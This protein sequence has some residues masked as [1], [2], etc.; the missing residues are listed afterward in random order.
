MTQPI[1]YDSSE[2]GAPTLN[3]VA[4]SLLT[5]LRACLISGFN[6]KSVTSIT[7]ASGVATVTCAAHGFSGTY[8]K[9]VQISG[10]TE[11]LLNGNKQPGNVLTNSFTFPAPGVA[12][13]TYTGT[14]SAK[15]APL[16]WTEP[17]TG[18]NVAMF[19][20][21]VPEA[22][23][24][25][26][27]VDDSHSA[28]STVTDARMSMVESATS[29]NNFTDETPTSA[30]VSGGFHVS[31]G[32]NSVTAKRWVIFGTGREIWLGSQASPGVTDPLQMYFFGDCISY[33]SPDPY[34][35]IIAGA[36]AA[37]SGTAN[38]SLL[39]SWASVNSANLMGGNR[40]AVARD[41]KGT[42]KS[43]ICNPVGLFSGVANG[44]AIGGSGLAQSEAVGVN[45]LIHQYVWIQ[46]PTR[47]IRGHFPGIK[48]PLG[49]ALPF[50]DMQILGD[51]GGSGRSF[52]SVRV[53]T[54]F[55]A[56]NVLFDLTGPWG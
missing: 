42:D 34:A 40:I 16:G 20:R 51:V 1:W 17:H 44:N 19:A 55:G 26:L 47:P 46:Q 7:V 5:V 53:G 54:A 2:A 10:A 45:V 50:S 25:L 39:G 30:Q 9:L 56:A 31:K 48:A 27:R 35:C 21:S 36:L 12:D 8:G 37:Y 18:T 49:Y 43:I 41:A 24:M 15:R 52:I 4:G 38:N 6:S 13:G 29:V 23:A 28:P 14:L 33:S 3:N 32:P 22:T 11:P